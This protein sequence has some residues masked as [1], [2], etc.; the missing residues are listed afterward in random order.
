[1]T[2]FSSPP[3]SNT[4]ASAARARTGDLPVDPV[5]VAGYLAGSWCLGFAAVSGWQLASGPVPDGPL[6]AYAGG[7]AAMIILVLVLKLLG[8]LLALLAVHPGPLRIRSAWLATGLWGAVGLLAVYSAGSIALA[9]GTITG[10]IEPTAAWERAGGATPR[11]VLYVL[12]FLAGAFLFG[13]LAV[14]FHRRH[15]PPWTAA[16]I[17]LLGG[18]FL[19]GFV[20][21]VAPRLLGHFGLLPL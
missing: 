11:S 12:F 10:L 3:P 5:R 8:A 13:V 4:N 19:L 18:P 9:V 1:M 16:A 17:G 20:L 7:I 14:S 21:V 6:A 2:A 15:R